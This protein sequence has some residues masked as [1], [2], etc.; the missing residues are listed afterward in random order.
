MASIDLHLHTLYSDDGQLIPTELVQKCIKNGIKYAAVAD[1]NTTKGV[2]EAIKAARWKD[3]EI[4]P[5]IE[6]D[7]MHKGT[8]LH[9]L[10][11]GIDYA[12]P[13][14]DENEENILKQEQQA[15][16]TRIRLL[17][18]AGF[19]FDDNM[20][21]SL[22]RN[23][24]VNGEM[25]AEAA[26]A[27]DKDHQNLL[28]QP[29]FEG[30]SRSDNPQVNFY[31]DYCHQGKP[32]Y[33]E[34]KYISLSEAVRMIVENHGVPILA[35]PGKM[36]NEDRQILEELIANGVEGLEVY[37]S[38][39]LPEQTRFYRDFCVERKLLIT[40]GSDFH[41][42]TKPKIKIGSTDC[43]GQELTIIQALKQALRLHAK[44]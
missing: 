16:K 29:Y 26:M 11:Y 39:H 38:Y 2:S 6:L 22:S 32:G 18:E 35:H 17:R 33:V 44:I 9:I 13:V 37:S 27:F 19:Q 21:A 7:C 15:S 4:I 41:G 24:V 10:G 8:N 36:V 28:L 43:E 3:L 14:F 5:G 31:W 20:I 1:H 30:G 40:C 25:I 34:I 23:G 12:S 42:K